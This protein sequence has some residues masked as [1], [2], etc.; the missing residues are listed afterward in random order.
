VINA[1]AGAGNL[2]RGATQVPGFEPGDTALISVSCTGFTDSAV[3]GLVL[4]WLPDDVIN[5][6]S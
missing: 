1:P 3:T 5:A 4:R 2:Q 6:F